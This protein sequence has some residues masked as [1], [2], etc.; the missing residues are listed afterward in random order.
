MKEIQTFLSGFWLIGDMRFTSRFSKKTR[1]W[2][3]GWKSAAIISTL[4]H[5]QQTDGSLDCHWSFTQAGLVTPKNLLNF[6]H[7]YKLTDQTFFFEIIY[8]FEADDDFVLN[9]MIK[10]VAIVKNYA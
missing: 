8:P 3:F 6:W 1:T 5:I 4:F 9:D 10:T 7:N 2:I